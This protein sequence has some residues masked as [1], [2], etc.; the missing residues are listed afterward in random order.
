METRNCQL[1]KD[2]SENNEIIS[3]LKRKDVFQ[4]KII[5]EL[6]S[7]LNQNVN[8]FGKLETSVFNMASLVHVLDNKS[9]E[10]NILINNVP[11]QQFENSGQL[12]AIVKKNVKN[13]DKNVT[14]TGAYRKGEHSWNS[15]KIVQSFHHF[16]TTNSISQYI[17]THISSNTLTIETSTS[18]KTCAKNGRQHGRINSHYIMK[19]GKNTEMFIF[20]AK[21]V[22]TA[23]VS[24]GRELTNL[25]S[26]L[27]HSLT[28]RYSNFQ[29]PYHPPLAYCLTTRHFSHPPPSC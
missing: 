21:C 28:T 3:E 7:K 18:R 20:E 29:P 24:T 5:N 12:I 13:I 14:V 23:T 19:K 4:T 2:V 1:E 26:V 15:P 27:T 16:W 6:K 9:R 8:N 11:E 10:K 17:G 25:F 22:S